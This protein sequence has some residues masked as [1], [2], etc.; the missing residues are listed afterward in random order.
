M[1]T[2]KHNSNKD[3]AHPFRQWNPGSLAKQ[4]NP[5]PQSFLVWRNDR[6]KHR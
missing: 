5:K 4:N 2:K 6:I 3:P 1:I